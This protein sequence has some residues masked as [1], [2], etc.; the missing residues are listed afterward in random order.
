MA[1]KDIWNNSEWEKRRNSALTLRRWYDGTALVQ[2]EPAMDSSGDVVERYPMRLN[3][4]ELE[5]DLHKDI[6]RGMPQNDESPF[7]QAVMER[8]DDKEKAAELEDI[9]NVKIWKASHGGPIQQEGLLNMNIYG[10]CVYSIRW[11]PWESFDLPLGLAVRHIQNPSLVYPVSVDYL[12]PWRMLEVYFGYEISPAFAKA[13]YGISTDK[14]ENDRCLYME[15]WTVDE[16]SIRVDDMRA[17]VNF[18]GEKIEL[19]GK[20]PFGFVPFYYIPHKRGTSYYGKSQVQDKEELSKELNARMIGVADLVRQTYAGMVWVSD[21]KSK[22]RVVSLMDS[23]SRALKY[24]DLG[25]TVSFGS[26]SKSPKMGAIPVP[27]VPEF[28]GSFHW[29][30]IDMWQIFARISPATLGRDDTRSGRITGPAVAQRMFSGVSHAT[31]E[32]D[33]YSTGKTIIDR[34]LLRILANEDTRSK[35]VEYGMEP[36]E[37]TPE[38]LR[39]DISQSWPPM[40]PLDRTEKHREIIDR[41]R[42]GVVGLPSALKEYGVA[43]VEGEKRDIEEWRTGEAQRKAIARPSFFGQDQDNDSRAGEP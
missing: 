14:S 28:A 15:H 25:D 2:K 41:F 20:N 26:G 1:D 17:V 10:G 12:N 39:L 37:V 21:V 40:I 36:P 8:G 18:E 27:D 33:Y 31:T 13:K 29:D 38:D 5:C 19:A 23:G 7:V 43:D 3:I 16:Y 30:I 6:A 4:H 22:M 24:V 9:L 32:R 42:E 35:M 11:E 34:D